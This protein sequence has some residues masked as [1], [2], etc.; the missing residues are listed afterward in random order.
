MPLYNTK[1]VIRQGYKESVMQECSKLIR[2]PRQYSELLQ[3]M[4]RN[5]VG[6][7]VWETFTRNARLM[8]LHNGNQI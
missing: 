2:H 1:T 3:D 6:P 5:P 8:S 7:N 4:N